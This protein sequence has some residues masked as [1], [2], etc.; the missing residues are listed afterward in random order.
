MAEDWQLLVELA[1]EME[2]PEPPVQI[3]RRGSGDTEN[4]YEIIDTRP[5]SSES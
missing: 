4:G 1:I 2:S 5:N 3:D